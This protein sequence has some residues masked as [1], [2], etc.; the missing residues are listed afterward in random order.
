MM[1]RLTPDLL[2]DVTL[3]RTQDGGRPYPLR[4]DLTDHFSCPCKI[5]KDDFNA[6]DAR[7]LIAGLVIQPGDSRRLGMAFLSAPQAV[8]LFVQAGH[9]YLWEGGIIGEVQVVELLRDDEVSL[10]GL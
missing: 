4:G 3:Y 5:N 10:R 2:V 6:W 7:L 8:P 9:F 1:S